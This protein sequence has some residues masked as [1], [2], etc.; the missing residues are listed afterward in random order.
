[1]AF[2]VQRIL[3]NDSSITR[4]Y[5]GGHSMGGQNAAIALEYLRGNIKVPVEAFCINPA[6][7]HPPQDRSNISVIRVPGDPVPSFWSNKATD[8]YVKPTESTYRSL[9]LSIWWDEHALAPFSRE[10]LNNTKGNGFDQYMKHVEKY[11]WK[12]LRERYLP[13]IVLLPFIYPY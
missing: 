13:G 2:E 11:G 12:G 10:I 7:L 3:E 6:G 9:G 1:M 8:I 5:I 4:V